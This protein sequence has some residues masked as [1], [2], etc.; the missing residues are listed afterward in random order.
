M[1]PPLTD[2]SPTGE[3]ECECGG[4]RMISTDIDGPFQGGPICER[5]LMCQK[6]K[7]KYVATQESQT[8]APQQQTATER[9]VEKFAQMRRDGLQDMKLQYVGPR[10]GSVSVEELAEEVL[11][12]IEA[13]ER[14]DFVDIAEK[15]K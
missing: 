10:D 12:M 9:L 3:R 15:L 2:H 4:R 13:F 7:E 1:T 5:G 11:A 14:K 6:G 8:P